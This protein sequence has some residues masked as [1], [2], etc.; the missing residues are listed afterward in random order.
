MDASDYTQLPVATIPALVSTGITILYFVL[1][2]LN[3]L[4]GA[5]PGAPNR[6]ETKRRTDQEGQPKQGSDQGGRCQSKIHEQTQRH[7]GQERYGEWWNPSPTGPIFLRGPGEDIPLHAQRDAPEHNDMPSLRTNDERLSSRGSTGT[8]PLTC[9]GSAS[10]FDVSAGLCQQG[11]GQSNTMN[12]QSP[13]HGRTGI[14]DEPTTTQPTTRNNAAR[15]QRF[16]EATAS[17]N[18]G[19]TK[20]ETVDTGAQTDDTEHFY[21]SKDTILAY[22]IAV[23]Q[24]TRAY[25]FGQ[26]SVVF[27]T[28]QNKAALETPS[29]AEEFI[30]EHFNIRLLTDKENYT[31]PPNAQAHKRKASVDA[32]PTNLTQEIVPKVVE[33]SDS[34]P[35]QKSQP[36]GTVPPTCR[37]KKGTCNG[38]PAGYKSDDSWG[39]YSNNDNPQQQTPDL[40]EELYPLVAY[41]TWK[42]PYARPR[43]TPRGVPRDS[44]H[45]APNRQIPVQDGYE[46]PQR[47]WDGQP[48]SRR[49]RSQ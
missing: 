48:Y 25:H 36:T 28:A 8:S 46:Q 22:T 32:T 23:V 33:P 6:K 34:T 17:P 11:T 10:S 15:V 26:M 44:H 42:R 7:S 2:L 16:S 49:T 45:R 30:N 37:P 31:G 41:Q 47:P 12:E 21:V 18:P 43:N 1:K 29:R 19:S 39:G 5:K 38:I 14:Q 35:N 4:T 9:Q 40:D 13:C 27:Q 24:N 3:Y 20:T